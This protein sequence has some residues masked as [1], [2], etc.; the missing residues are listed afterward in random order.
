MY[1]SNMSGASQINS[2]LIIA[3]KLLNDAK[4]WLGY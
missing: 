4:G 2:T 1:A 3:K